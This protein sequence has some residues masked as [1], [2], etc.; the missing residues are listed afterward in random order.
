MDKAWSAEW[1]RRFS[2]TDPASL[3]DLYSEDASFEDVTLGQRV[4]GKSDL[5]GFFG[6]F[7][8]RAERTNRFTLLRYVGDAKSGAIEW[9]WEARHEG[10]FLGQAARGKTTSVRGVSVLEFDGGKVR[11]Q[12]DYWDARTLLAQLSAAQ[13]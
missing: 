4:S 1:L 3:I 13:R 12:R 11:E 7:M 8:N 2:A 5:A 10:N 9:M 6:A